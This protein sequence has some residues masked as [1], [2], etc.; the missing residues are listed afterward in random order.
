MQEITE[1]QDKMDHQNRIITQSEQ[2]S[3]ET[4]QKH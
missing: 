1:K 4:L 2:L 3:K